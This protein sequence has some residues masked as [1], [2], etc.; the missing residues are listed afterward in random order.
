MTVLNMNNEEQKE[1]SSELTLSDMKIINNII[2]LVASKGL[3][4]PSDFCIIGNI[5]DKINN[6]LKD[7]ES[8]K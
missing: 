8:Q 7:N 4:R 2:E 6:L 3:F 1:I 5:Y